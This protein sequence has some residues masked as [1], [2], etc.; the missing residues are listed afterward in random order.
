MADDKPLILVDGSSYLFRAYHA[1]PPLTTSTGK[2]TG[3]V[4]GVIGMLRKLMSDYPGSTVAVVFDAKGKTFRNDLYAEY[5]ANRPPM[6][7]DLREQIEPIHQIVDAMG[8]PRLVV[9]GV[10]ADDVIGTLARQASAQQREVIVSTSDKDLAQLVDDHVT[11]VNTMSETVMDRDG[12][13]EKFGVP[14]ERIVDMLALTGDSVDNIP[15]VPKVGP[16]TAVKWIGQFGDLDGVMA[17][18]EE[19]GGKVGEHLRGA[20]D[21]LRLARDLATIRCDL[22]LDLGPADLA[23][24]EVDEERLLAL[25][26]DLEFKGWISE[27]SSRVEA[28]PHTE[29]DYETVLDE[30]SFAAW[31]EALRKADGFAFDTETTSLRYMQADLVGVSFAV[32]P[33]RAAYVPFGHAYVG[34]PDQ[35]SAE[36][37]LGALGPLLP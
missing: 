1:L 33:G 12:V 9:D 29:R 24:G 32:E 21:Q 13:I 18:A 4:K 19:V 31:V 2:P 7:D 34:A 16:K 25:Y 20:L 14:P 22:E 30:D 6:P 27:V 37:V 3:A 28:A 15:G 26:R 23:Q 8:L 10:E 5:K 35:L 17:H 36:Q 11:L